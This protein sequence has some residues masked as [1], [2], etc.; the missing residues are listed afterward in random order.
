M[1]DWTMRA[2]FLVAVVAAAATMGVL[3]VVLTGRVEEAV[4]RRFAH[5]LCLTQQENRAA[6][7]RIDE[8]LVVIFEATVRADPP[9]FHVPVRGPKLKAA[10][11]K[12]ISDFR[13]DAAKLKPTDCR[14][15]LRD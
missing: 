12:A 14:M 1:N 8:N 10:Y 9:G 11:E 5:E 13:T 6:V 4:S 7:R 2:V 3:T 15:S